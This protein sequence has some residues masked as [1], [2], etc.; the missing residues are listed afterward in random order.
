MYICSSKNR[1]VLCHKKSNL[2]PETAKFKLN[3]QEK[4]DV[5]MI[6]CFQ[7]KMALT[8]FLFAAVCSVVQ[9]ELPPKVY[10]KMKRNADEYVSLEVLDLPPVIGLPGPC[11]I[12]NYKAKVKIQKVHRKPSDLDVGDVV[13]LKTWRRLPGKNC[14]VGPSSPPTISEGWCGNVYMDE[15]SGRRKYEIAAGGKSFEKVIGGCLD[16]GPKNL[17]GCLKIVKKQCSCI[18]GLRSK[19]ARVRAARTCA[20]DKA[21]KLCN[22]KTRAFKRVQSKYANFCT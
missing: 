12:Y 14:P 11:G 10:E 19:K 4:V 5:M 2:T 22:L 13:T 1:L 6:G 7:T 8:I 15:A 20:R 16:N 3:F 17:A 18:T 9:C 21:S